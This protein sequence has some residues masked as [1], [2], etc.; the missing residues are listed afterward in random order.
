MVTE[1]EGPVLLWEWMFE[2]RSDSWFSVPFHHPVLA[3]LQAASR[4]RG[5][6]VP[7]APEPACFFI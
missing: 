4:V 7:D 5:P 6:S 3:F 1:L 2:I